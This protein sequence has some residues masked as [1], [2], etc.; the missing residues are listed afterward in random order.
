M[1]LLQFS[2]KTWAISREFTRPQLWVMNCVN[3]ICLKARIRED[4][5]LEDLS[6]VLPSQTPTA[7]LVSYLLALK[8][9]PTIADKC[10]CADFLLSAFFPPLLLEI[11]NH[12]LRFIVHSLCGFFQL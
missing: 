6:G 4:D 10:P 2:L 12:L 1:F 7:K 5:F 3:L 9:A 11:Q 8:A